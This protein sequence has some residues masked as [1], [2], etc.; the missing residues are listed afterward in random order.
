MI[1]V[2]DLE[3]VNGRLTGRLAGPI[4]VGTQKVS[5]LKS[6]GISSL[7]AAFG[8]T[9]P[10]AAMLEMARKPVVIP[11]DKKLEQLALEHGWRILRT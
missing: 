6:R 9:L 4:N 11:T 10:D 7:E 2:S 1:V 3:V 8:D 5:G